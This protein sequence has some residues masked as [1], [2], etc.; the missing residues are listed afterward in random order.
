MFSHILNEIGIS[1]IHITELKMHL[2]SIQTHHL[3]VWMQL[4]IFLFPSK[5]LI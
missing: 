3:R 4:Q 5:V 1:L 2:I